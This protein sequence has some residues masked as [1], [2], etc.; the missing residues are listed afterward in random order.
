MRGL[1]AVIGF[2]MV[3][4]FVLTIIKVIGQTFWPG[5]FKGRRRR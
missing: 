3:A 1:I 4:Y 2:F 5:T